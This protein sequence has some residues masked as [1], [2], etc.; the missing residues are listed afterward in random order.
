MDS[1]K[2]G[3]EILYDA[4]DAVIGRLASRIA[5]DLLNGARVTVINAEKSIITGDIKSL[6]ERYKTRLDLQEKENPEHSPYWSRRPDLLFKR[7]VRGMLPYKKARGRE[8]YKR[9]KVYMGVPEEL[10]NKESTKIEIKRKESVYVDYVTLY[11]LCK[12]LGYKG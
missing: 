3:N 8:A 12:R 11:G 9:L 7:I 5:K 6:Y 4:T 10:K 1:D 2:S